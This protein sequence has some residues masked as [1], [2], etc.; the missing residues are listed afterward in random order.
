M[1]TNKKVTPYQ[2]R[3]SMMK[4]SPFN[5]IITSHIQQKYQKIYDK[6]KKMAIGRVFLWQNCLILVCHVMFMYVAHFFACWAGVCCQAIIK[7]CEFPSNPPKRET[8]HRLEDGSSRL[9]EMHKERKSTTK[10][11]EMLS[12]PWLESAPNRAVLHGAD[13]AIRL[14]WIH[15]PSGHGAWWGCQWGGGTSYIRQTETICLPR[16]LRWHSRTGR[17]V[18]PHAGGAQP[19]EVT[20]PD[21]GL[22][23]QLPANGS[24]RYSN[25]CPFLVRRL[26]KFLR[27][28][29][30]A[31][32][33]LDKKN[34][35]IMSKIVQNCPIMSNNVQ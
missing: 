26:V 19:R 12:A 15:A 35:P 27:L 29:L 13:A 30:N 25:W 14:D 21:H 16:G 34:C 31:R 24:S 7:S 28:W 11:D 8:N 1:R 9:L 22:C 17:R 23:R 33:S 6:I 2:Y 5:R 18:G 20:A 4:V 3:R 10:L 32:P